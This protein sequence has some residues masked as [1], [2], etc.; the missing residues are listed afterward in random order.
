M[1]INQRWTLQGRLENVT[2]QHYTLADGY[3]TAGRS[4][5]VELRYGQH[6]G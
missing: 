2:A 5:Y 3:N 4:L 6:L 1:H